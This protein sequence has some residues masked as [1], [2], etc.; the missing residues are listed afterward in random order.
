MMTPTPV[1]T[2]T[3][4]QEFPVGGWSQTAQGGQEF[5]VVVEQNVDPGLQMPEG[6]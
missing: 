5:A 3:Q 1:G 4:G 6:S 2:T